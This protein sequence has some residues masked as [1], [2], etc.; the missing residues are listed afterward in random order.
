MADPVVLV[1]G[2]AGGIGGAT[3]RRFATA[4]WRVAAT[5]QDARGLSR[6]AEELGPA[7]AASLTANLLE[8]NE[9]R[10]A[11]ADAI[12]ATGRLDCLVN[13][14][15]LWTEGRTDDTREEDFDRVV[16]VNLKGLFFL[17]AAAIP[18]LERTGGCVVSLSSDAGLQGNAGAA[19]Y[20]ASKGAVSNLT[21]ALAL[22]LAPRG[23]R[24]NAVCPADV[25]T[26]MLRYQA[27]T[28]GGGDPEGY[29][30][31]LQQNYPQGARTR[32]LRPEEVADLIFYLAQPAAAGIT[33]ANVSIDFGLSAGIV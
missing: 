24:V 16:G 33:G 12:A 1:S 3:A 31:R 20:C 27:E 17:T 2:A 30:R 26:P 23:I 11:V 29:R 21:R 15:G 10:G 6:L 25:E 4:G 22:E 9:C 5:D 28:F 13:A 8:V 14:A 7:L 19:I 32:F 18:H